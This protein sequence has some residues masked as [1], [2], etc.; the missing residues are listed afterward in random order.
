VS[1]RGIM[2][3]LGHSQISL[4]LNTYSHVQAEMQRQA[5]SAMEAVLAD[6]EETA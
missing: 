5:A 6:E 4:P 1:A 2:E 3:V